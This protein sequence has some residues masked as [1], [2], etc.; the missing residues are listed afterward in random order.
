MKG[1]ARKNSHK[2]ETQNLSQV[3]QSAAAAINFNKYPI[4]FIGRQ[5]INL[6]EKQITSKNLEP[7]DAC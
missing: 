2:Q 1:K 7:L 4:K 5:L 3:F 6:G